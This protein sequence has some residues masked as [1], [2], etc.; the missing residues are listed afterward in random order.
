MTRR[1]KRWSSDEIWRRLIDV[2]L[3]DVY[4]CC[5]ESAK[6]MLRRKHGS[7]ATLGSISGTISN[8]PQWQAHYNAAKAAVH[9]LTKSLAGEWAEGGARVN[10]VAP[11][12]VDTPMSNTSFDNPERMPI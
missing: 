4:W 2:D 7:I 8:K 3:S 9:R 11:T 12:Y 6:Y 10:C 5:R 1:S